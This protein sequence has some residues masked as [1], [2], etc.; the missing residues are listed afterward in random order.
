MDANVRDKTLSAQTAPEVTSFC[1]VPGFGWVISST[2]KPAAL[3][4]EN[5]DKTMYP[6]K[7]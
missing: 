4:R 5:D 3:N 2:S 6:G 7:K 1:G